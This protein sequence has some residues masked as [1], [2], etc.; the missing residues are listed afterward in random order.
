MQTYALFLHADAASFF[1]SLR[2]EEK[3]SLRRFLDVLEQYPT[4]V[5]EATE[6]DAVG[7]SIQVKFVRR[8][9]AVY[10]ANH[11]DKEIKVLRL[12]RLRAGLAG[13]LP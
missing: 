6:R 10:W 11:A 9:K 2:R 1:H 7:R 3:E 4:I 5:G 12:E 8:L 13:R